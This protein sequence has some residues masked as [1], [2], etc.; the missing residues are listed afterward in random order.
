MIET[1]EFYGKVHNES[2]ETGL[3]RIPDN[4]VDCVLTDP[5]YLYL[6]HKLDAPF[7]ENLFFSEVKRILKPAGFIVLFGRG[8]S[9]YRWNTMLAEAGFKF[10]EEIVWDKSYCSS[11]LMAL[12]RIHETVSIH[13]KKNGTINRA[14]V[15]YLEMK[16]HDIAGIVTDIKRLKTCLK[17]TK[18]LNAVLDFLENNERSYSGVCHAS[19]TISSE[20][21]GCDRCV[22]VLSAMHSGMNEKSVIKE[23][24][25]HYKTI[26]PTQKPV[27]LLERLLALVTKP[28]DFVVDPFAGSGSTIK[29]CINTGR[30]STGFEILKEYA[31]SA[32]DSIMHLHPKLELY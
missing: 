29:A 27:R 17:N 23:P 30:K 22:N 6:E 3:K 26:H 2:F 18:S 21:A 24:R 19:T 31:D 7:D 4:S 28:G 14:K 8:S 20:I 12:S 9:F 10:K 32:N 13:T 15:P 5:P 11:P 1:S 25:D 16:K